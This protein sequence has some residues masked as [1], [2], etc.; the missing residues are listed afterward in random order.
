VAK[1][2]IAIYLWRSIANN[3][4]PD[5]PASRRGNGFGAGMVSIESA[6]DEGLV[7]SN[8]GGDD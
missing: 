8:F 5:L 3:D 1:D 7:E 4:L 2:L 6:G